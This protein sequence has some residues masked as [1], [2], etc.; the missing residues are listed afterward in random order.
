MTRKEPADL[1]ASMAELDTIQRARL[2]GYRTKVAAL[3]GFINNPHLTQAMDDEVISGVIAA[4]LFPPHAPALTETYHALAINLK[5]PA[6]S[7]LR[8]LRLVTVGDMIVTQSQLPITDREPF[9]DRGNVHG[10]RSKFFVDAMELM[11]AEKPTEQSQT[12]YQAFMDAITPARKRLADPPPPHAATPDALR[13]QAAQVREVTAFLDSSLAHT[14]ARLGSDTVVALL[15]EYP[16]KSARQIGEDAHA[17]LLLVNNELEG[18]DYDLEY[19][20]WV[21]H[22]YRGTRDTDGNQTHL[23]KLGNYFLTH[24]SVSTVFWNRPNEEIPAVPLPATAA[25]DRIRR[26]TVPMQY[27]NAEWYFTQP[28]ETALAFLQTTPLEGDQVLSKPA[29]LKRLISYA[30]LFKS[31]HPAHPN[32]TV[33]TDELRALIRGSGSRKTVSGFMDILTDQQAGI[34]HDEVRPPAPP[35]IKVSIVKAGQTAAELLASLDPDSVYYVSDKKAEETKRKAR[36]GDS[37]STTRTEPH[38]QEI[39]AHIDGTTTTAPYWHE[40]VEPHAASVPVVLDAL[41]KRFGEHNQ[42]ETKKLSTM[43]DDPLDALSPLTVTRSIAV[44]PAILPPE[45]L[46]H[47]LSAS[48]ILA[49][50]RDEGRY[51]IMINTDT[52]GIDSQGSAVLRL[53]GRL[54]EFGLIIDNAPDEFV[55]TPLQNALTGAAIMTHKLPDKTFTLDKKSEGKK[56]AAKVSVTEWNIIAKTSGFP[57]LSPMRPFTEKETAVVYPLDQ[58]H[59]DHFAYEKTGK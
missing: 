22:L 25:S 14:H 53:Q 46:L 1:A 35:Q 57:T 38:P 52:A 32:V 48:G 27:A 9:T 31:L 50:Q 33:I 12:A 18:E 6:T 34:I 51:S 11:I 30:G 23:D 13:Q 43:A 7:P 4:T 45:H 58:Q 54:T 3:P 44:V 49:I 2:D 37:P 42:N 5:A 17:G 8:Q 10:K 19:H 59:V 55:Y 41:Q 21:N 28:P 16:I 47:N 29:L 24:D 39:R 40:V 20:A 36:N 15:H 56:D 26:H